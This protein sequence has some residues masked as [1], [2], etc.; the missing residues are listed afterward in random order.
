MFDAIVLWLHVLGAVVFIGPQVFLAAVAMPALRSVSDVQARQQ[1]TRAITRGFG[2]LGGAALALLLVTGIYNFYDR[3]RFIDADEFPRYFFV[4][5]VKLTLVTVVIV[6]T[7]LHAMVLGRRLQRLQE[8]GAP[9]A[10]VAA[11]RRWSM[12]ASIG[13]LTV[14]IAILLCAALLASD[15]SKL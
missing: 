15:W 9:E 4:L 5:Q 7:A 6:L 1:A 12:I 14:S 10:E 8:S 13:T 3:E 2:M 11:A